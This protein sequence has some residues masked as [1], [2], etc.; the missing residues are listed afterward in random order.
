[1]SGQFPI[2]F[3]FAGE[4]NFD[5]YYSGVNREVVENLRACASGRGEQLI[6]LWGEAGLGKSHLL[7]ACC[8][9]ADQNG[10]RAFYLSLSEYASH[11]PVILDEMALLP[12][13]CIDDINCV[14]GNNDWERG[15]FNLFN[16]SRAAGNR[17]IISADQPPAALA[18]RLADLKTR[19]GWGLI[20]QL[21]PFNDE[22]KLAALIQYAD[23]LGY[24]LTPKVGRFLLNH[25]VRDL[26]T[27]WSILDQLERATLAAQRKLTIP[28]LKAFLS[29]VQV[30]S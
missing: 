6:F 25:H 16:D 22:E 18:V 20:L 24:E 12:L 27:L 13:L 5:H 28:F 15:L 1:M 29:S 17:L 8:Q 10:E 9:S 26:P 21:Q 2:H 19:L 4:D 30:K 3:Q 7:R 23:N 14:I 11:G